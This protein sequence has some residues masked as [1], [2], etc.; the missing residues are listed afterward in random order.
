[1]TYKLRW[2]RSQ[3]RRQRTQIER[4]T[5]EEKKKAAAIVYT[6][7]IKPHGLRTYLHGKK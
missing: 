4:K 2:E 6:N 1:M 5:K 7:F 3:V